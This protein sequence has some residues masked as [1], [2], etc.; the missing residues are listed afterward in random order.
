MGRKAIP[1]CLLNRLALILT[2]FIFGWLLI[3]TTIAQ[4]ST[5]TDAP[6][7]TL[8]IEFVDTIPTDSETSRFRF[9]RFYLERNHIFVVN[10]P[11]DAPSTDPP[12]RIVRT[13]RDRTDAIEL[14]ITN[15]PID[16]SMVSPLLE[17]SDENFHLYHIFSIQDTNTLGERFIVAFLSF[18]MGNHALAQQDYARAAIF[19]EA[20]VDIFTST[21]L[22]CCPHEAPSV[23]LAWTYVQLGRNEDANRVMTNL[24]NLARHTGTGTFYQFRDEPHYRLRFL[25]EN[26][27]R[28]AQIYAL[29]FDYDAAIADMDRAIVLQPLNPRLYLIRGQLILLIYEWDRVLADY[30]RAISLR[31]DFADAY[32]Y[33]GILLYTQ[34]SSEQALVDFQHYIELAPNGEFSE[35]AMQYIEAIEHEQEALNE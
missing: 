15:P 2:S 31:P 7:T 1:M 28:R 34:H 9:I 26:L 16:F 17:G 3:H 21:D 27:T 11:T 35:Q 24:I 22:S 10:T 4:D 32:F 30:N 12:I 5:P 13:G 6:S 19:Y 25:V 14:T 18:F 33:R 8:Y 29:M 20:A 23:N